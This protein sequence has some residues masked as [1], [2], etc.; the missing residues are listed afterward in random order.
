[1]N[2]YHID[3][4]EASDLPNK[5]E[6]S[7]VAEINLE[8]FIGF[9]NTRQNA[10]DNLDEETVFDLEYLYALHREALDHLYDIA[11]QVR[12][13]NTSKD[14]FMF[15]A[16]EFLV[17]ALQAFE[18]EHLVPLNNNAWLDEAGFVDS[19][20]TMHAEILYIHPFREGNGR[21]IRL[22]TELIYLA[23]TGKELELDV[24]NEGDNFQRYVAAVQQAAGR[25]YDLMQQLF[26][27]L[28]A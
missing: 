27:E 5:L 21:V 15:P 22:F 17:A 26:R 24:L 12:T 9:S 3:G 18:D 19:L 8:E 10:I 4:K 25:E 1:M 28:S 16:A 11:G 20:A 7:D 2:R 6:L 23:K 14:G 13:V